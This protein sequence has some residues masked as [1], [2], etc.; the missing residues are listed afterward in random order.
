[1]AVCVCVCRRWSSDSDDKSGHISASSAWDVRAG[2]RR[3]SW[4]ECECYQTGTATISA[5]LIHLRLHWRQ[6]QGLP[7]HWQCTHSHSAETQPGEQLY[8]IWTIIVHLYISVIVRLLVWKLTIKNVENIYQNRSN[9]STL[10][11][12]I[13]Q[14]RVL[15]PVFPQQSNLPLI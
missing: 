8:S 7:A 5:Q 15:G 10:F 13:W 2:R 6:G 3:L 14:Y 11:A 12:L 9:Q 4:D 1:M